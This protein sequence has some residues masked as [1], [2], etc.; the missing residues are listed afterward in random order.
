MQMEI[1]SET[2]PL[3]LSRLLPQTKVFGVHWY[4][5]GE[6]ENRFLHIPS[7][8][9]CKPPDGLGF[10]KVGMKSSKCQS[11]R[12]LLPTLQKVERDPSLIIFLICNFIVISVIKICILK[13]IPLL[14]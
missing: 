14:S 7:P 9:N 4:G 5:H 10:S 12:S 2:L 6:E 1:T 8:S 3:S 13:H 11:F